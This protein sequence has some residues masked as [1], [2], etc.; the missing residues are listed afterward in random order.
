MGK[1]KTFNGVNMPQGNQTGT[2]E[3]NRSRAIS[4]FILGL[5]SFFLLNIS[6][7]GMNYWKRGTFEL[8]LLYVKL[9]IAFYFIWL[10][11]S[12]FTKKFRFDFYRSYRALM[13]LLTRSTIYIVYCVALMVVIMGLR[14]FSRL[15]VF[16]TCGLFFIGEVILFS[17]CYVMIRRT[18]V[19]Y[20]GTDY[21]KPKPKPKPKHLLVLSV[22]DFLLVTFIFFIVNYFKKGTFGLSPEYEKLLL[23]IY[24]LWFVTALITRKFD[25]G[26]RNY[27][28]AMAQWTKAVVFMAA[29]LAVIIFA[30]RLFYYSRFQ[31]VGFFFL[32]ILAESVLYYVYYVLS[33]S[34]KNDG[35]I[36]SIEEVR[37]V[38]RQ[39]ALSLDIDIEELR[40]RLTRPVKDK[41]REVFLDSPEVFDLLDQTLDLSRI[42]R[43]ESAIIHKKGLYHQKATNPLHIR[44]LIN[45]ERVNNIRWVNRYFLEAHNILLPGGYFVG[46]V[47][48]IDLYRKRFFEKYPKYF[49]QIF[50]SVN[51]IFR[52]VFPKLSVTKKLYFMITKGENR[53]ISRA[54]TLGRL[55]FCG[56]EII[57]EQEIDRNL[58]FIAR[59]VRT[60]SLSE[61]PSFGPLVKLNR[62]GIEGKPIT[63]Y[64]FRTMHPYSEFLQKYI[65]ERNSLQEGGKL[66]N[67]FRVTGWGKIMRK[68]WLDELPMLYNWMRGELKLVGV[69]PLSSHYLSLY[70]N[71]LQEMRKNTKPGLVPPFYVDLPKTF[72]EICES[73][74]RYLQAYKRNPIK[75]QC[76]YFIKAMYNIIIKNARSN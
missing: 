16:G 4:P 62:T 48:T 69:R 75:T 30:F 74:K 8:S 47:N 25:P 13:L 45:L 21:A 67:D 28:Y 46:R 50:Y 53:A 65:Y 71:E 52:R 68:Y 10:F 15:Q 3:V 23:I 17:F 35:D 32:L 7:F 18:K 20:A 26:Y 38:I 36:E 70:D 33:R 34:E 40:S 59:K 58:Y 55:C 72:N 51:F 73:E 49:S 61:N 60:A 44:L 41:L 54:E 64:K 19:A 39:E 24:G 11:V 1:R 14:G 56:F 76:S 22:S 6:F 5:V 31:M 27:Y 12:L 37:S 43:I 2:E 42:I 63:V 66:K 57:A 9:L 29:T